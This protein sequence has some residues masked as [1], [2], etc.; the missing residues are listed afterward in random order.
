MA[1]DKEEGRTRE[2]QADQGVTALRNPL[3]RIDSD[4]SFFFGR[5]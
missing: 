4:P 5:R 3:E 1:G 2:G